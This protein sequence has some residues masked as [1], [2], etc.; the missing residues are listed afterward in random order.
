[1]IE[2]VHTL[3][4]RSLFRYML[5]NITNMI[6]HRA[7]TQATG[8]YRKNTILGIETKQRDKIVKY[9]RKR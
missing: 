4:K 5:K 1:M 7:F 9:L 8:L 3:S 2:F 6:D